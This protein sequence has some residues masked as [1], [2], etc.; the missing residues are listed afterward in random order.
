MA[1]TVVAAGVGAGLA[2]HSAILAGLMLGIA[3]ATWWHDGG[4]FD[5]PDRVTVSATLAALTL[6][7]ATGQWDAGGHPWWQVLSLPEAFHGM[8]AGAGFGTLLLWMGEVVFRKP[9]LGFGD[10][11]LLAALGRL[12]GT[13]AVLLTIPLAALLA[14]A[15]MALAFAVRKRTTTGTASHG[16]GEISAAIL[17]PES[18]FAAGTPTD[19]V[20]LPNDAPGDENEIPAG[21]VPFGIAL[22][23]AAVLAPGVLAGLPPLF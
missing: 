23:I 5:I 19:A 15:G 9:A 8:V 20:Q 13:N 18:A 10:V 11:T 14:L 7:A 12:R 4:W 6:S 1:I 3:A 22:S 16:D 17:E 2:V 21:A